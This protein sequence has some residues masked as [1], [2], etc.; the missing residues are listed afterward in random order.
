MA[1]ISA[2]DQE[3]AVRTQEDE[4]ASRTFI[5]MSLLGLPNLLTLLSCPF[6]SIFTISS[7]RLYPLS[8]LAVLCR[9]SFL[10]L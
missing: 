6:H 10:V 9:V 3:D 8:S 7:S 1:S 4:M 2:M 5:E